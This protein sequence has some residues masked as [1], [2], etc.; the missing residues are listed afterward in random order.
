MWRP[1]K[2]TPEQIEERRMEGSRLL[3]EGNLSHAEIARRLGVRRNAV[4]QWARQIKQ[5]R[6]DLKSLK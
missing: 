4:S 6:R 1:S 2:L 3:R 5:R